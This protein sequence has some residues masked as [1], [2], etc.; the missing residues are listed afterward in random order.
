M[1]TR[2]KSLSVVFFF[3]LSLLFVTLL[4]GENGYFERKAMKEELERLESYAASREMDLALLRERSKGE[5]R[6]ESREVE[7]VYSFSEEDILPQNS[8][9]D[10]PKDSFVGLNVWNCALY[11]LIPTFVYALLIYLIPILGRKKKSDV[12]EKKDHGCDY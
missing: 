9:F 11:A 2:F 8:S 1:F 10:T 12:E 5:K 3:L 4:W 7:V 6:E